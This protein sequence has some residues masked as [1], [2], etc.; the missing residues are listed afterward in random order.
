MK[1]RPWEDKYWG[2]VGVG[3]SH[4]LLLETHCVLLDLG[5]WY[6]KTV[7]CQLS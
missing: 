3:A 1:E 4:F 6:Q 2:L 5:F 7:M